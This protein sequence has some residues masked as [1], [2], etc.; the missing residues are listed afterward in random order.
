LN[1]IFLPDLPPWLSGIEQGNNA[2]VLPD[3]SFLLFCLWAGMTI[4]F[5][6]QNKI[7]DGF[8]S[9]DISRQIFANL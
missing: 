5:A 8:T 1:N 3:G 2:G 4:P 9:Y 7:N 6:I